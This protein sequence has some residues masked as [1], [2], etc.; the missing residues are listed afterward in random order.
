MSDT[1][2]SRR[3]LLRAGVVIVAAGAGTWYGLRRGRPGSAPPAEVPSRAEAAAGE[4]F[5]PDYEA[6]RGQLLAALP[7]LI[8]PRETVDAFL[9]ALVAS[10]HKPRKPDAAVRRFLLSTDFFATGADESRPL[11]YAQLYDPYRNPCYNP[12]EPA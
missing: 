4:T 10:K 7:F 12:M 3:R 1:A 8:L 5:E 9:A 2:V 11:V 6:I